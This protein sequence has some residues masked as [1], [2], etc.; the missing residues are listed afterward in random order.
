MKSVVN[1]QKMIDWWQSERDI[2]SRQGGVDLG[3]E[4]FATGFLRHGMP[5]TILAESLASPVKLTIASSVSSSINTIIHRCQQY[6]FSPLNFVACMYTVSQGPQIRHTVFV[7]IVESCISP[8][9]TDEQNFKDG[10]FLYRF[11][12][13]DG[14]EGPK[15]KEGQR[16]LTALVSKVDFILT[17]VSCCRTIAVSGWGQS[18]WLLCIFVRLMYCWHILL[19]P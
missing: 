18:P 6:G 2:Q 3:Q 17:S 12:A 19:L 11:T 1:S 14:H 10:T 9:A 15:D 13:D 16:R 8:S 5:L 4:L 7:L